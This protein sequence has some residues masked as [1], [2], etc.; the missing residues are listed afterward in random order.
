MGEP[1]VLGCVRVR[2]LDYIACRKCCDW[3]VCTPTATEMTCTATHLRLKDRMRGW[4]NRLFA[5]GGALLERR[6]V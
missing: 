5:W 3:I 1:R 4:H 6:F 2:A